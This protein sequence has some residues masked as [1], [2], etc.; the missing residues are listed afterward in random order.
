M[1]FVFPV[2]AA[3]A[4]LLVLD[5]EAMAFGVLR[6]GGGTVTNIAPPAVITAQVHNAPGWQANTVYTPASGPKTRVNN[7]PGWTPAGGSSGTW[8]SG[9]LVRAYEL[10][11]GSCTSGNSGGP[12]GTGSSISD[13]TC[14]WKYL[15]DTDYVSLT[16][17]LFDNK[18][19]VAGSYNFHEWFVS[20]NPPRAYTLNDQPT[21]TVACVS[22]V[23]PTGTTGTAGP[24]GGTIVTT[25]DGC[26]W[27]Y[28]A[29]ITYSSQ[30]SYIP[31]MHW[32][33][34]VN[35][36][37]FDLTQAQYMMRSDYKA[38]LWNDR[39]YVAGTNG[40]ALPFQS[41]CHF[42]LGCWFTEDGGLIRCGSPFPACHQI[43]IMPAAGESFRDALAGG[44][45][46]V[47]G[48]NIANGVG[49]HNTNTGFKK[50]MAWLNRDGYL[51]F[52]GLQVKSDHGAA[53]EGQ[54]EHSDWNVFNAN[55]L[56]GGD[57]G[58]IGTNTNGHDPVLVVDCGAVTITNNLILS[59]GVGGVIGTFPMNILH[60]TFIQATP[61]TNSFG[62]ASVKSG[63]AFPNFQQLANNAFFG[64]VHPTAYTDPAFNNLGGN[65]YGTA[66]SVH[67]F[68]DGSGTDSGVS[69]TPEP[70]SFGTEAM[71]STPVPGG[72][73][74]IAATA[75]FVNAASDFRLANGS[76]LVGAGSV[77]GSW[78]LF[79]ESSNC[80][81]NSNGGGSPGTLGIVSY[82]TPDLINTVRPQGA[83]FD[84]GAL[85]QVSAAVITVADQVNREVFQRLGTSRTV[86]F[87][88]TVT[89][90]TATQI[91]CQIVDQSNHA[92]IIVD[93]TPVG[94]QVIGG[95]TWSGT[96]LV[97]QGLK[98]YNHRCRDTAN[99]GAS[100]FSTNKWG[101]GMRILLIGQ[102]DQRSIYDGLGE[103]PGPT[104]T[105][106]ASIW[107][108][109][110]V[111]AGTTT[112]W[113][114]IQSTPSSASA[115]KYWASAATT[116]FGVNVGFLGF[117]VNGSGSSSWISPS[118]TNY[119]LATGSAFGMG[120]AEVGADF[121]MAVW[122]QGPGDQCVACT[123]TQ[124]QYYN[125][126]TNIYNWV[127]A[128]ST[129]AGHSA[130]AKDFGFMVDIQGNQST[131]FGSAPN[132]GSNPATIDP[133]RQAQLQFATDNVHAGAFLGDF[134]IDTVHS[135]DGYITAW[136]DEHA[137]RHVYAQAHY[138][139]PAHNIN[140]V[141]PTLASAA[142]DL[143]TRKI[144][145][146]TFTFPSGA[147]ALQSSDGGAAVYGTTFQT[148]TYP[149]HFTTGTDVTD[150]G[151]SPS[152]WLGQV[153]AV[154]G[155]GS[156]ISPS[157]LSFSYSSAS[158]ITV[159]S[160]VAIAT[161]ITVGIFN[162]MYQLPSCSG[163]NLQQSM[164]WVL[165]HDNFASFASPAVLGQSQ[166]TRGFPMML[167]VG[168]I[169]AAGQ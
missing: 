74:N 134:P 157:N 63:C 129:A 40:E 166:M 101:V 70:F 33:K 41:G 141:G 132:W 159:T 108:L 87:S 53:F 12:T 24:H 103:N 73:Y 49:L 59:R 72:T 11:S 50:N 36:P 20:D 21:T 56:D 151:S 10:T 64:Y 128:L 135:C 143:A 51:D 127:S 82:D 84:V 91:Q 86:A 31:T 68:T 117:S 168:Q 62:V 145:T 88:G 123:T 153:I 83:S 79:C 119:L 165:P 133:V 106:F 96:I 118:S 125:N 136:M 81:P 131:N 144:V 26:H 120:R 99:G 29:D 163:A 164:A 109:M 92:T 39:E 95:G 124:V 80:Q 100:A 158:T 148:N 137:V 66:A 60:N 22:T 121:E 43:I 2:L 152:P 150:L 107:D 54:T 5:G 75:V 37:T 102:S 42:D 9:S 105:D 61:F 138:L 115:I 15:S 55:I 13:G 47:A 113:T 65:F 19:W 1:R 110:F 3:L 122:E 25:S 116:K 69:F 85:E 155:N 17:F 89:S 147:T 77:F 167:T 45:T 162:G 58:T 154:Y 94:S 98:W 78:T 111:Q 160:S 16:G 48:Y 67:N 38:L 6:T 114:A 18:P 44:G 28:V 130:I 76:P 139:D 7:G 93:W 52:E 8:T 14:T 27:L 104:A 149:F 156:Q 34:S 23:A 90:G 4:W 169:A 30:K 112:G 142:Y 71:L 32:V 126:L 97:P 146:L 35:P 161:P 140:P 46:A 57:D